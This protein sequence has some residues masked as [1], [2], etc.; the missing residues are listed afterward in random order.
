MGSDS[1]DIANLQRQIL[2]DVSD[3]VITHVH[4][5]DNTRSHTCSH[6]FLLVTLVDLV[7]LICFL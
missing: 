1:Q 3:I 5:H 7:I 6:D 2:E 4:S